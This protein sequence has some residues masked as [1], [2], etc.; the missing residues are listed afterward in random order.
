[1][2]IN[3]NRHDDKHALSPRTLV[4]AMIASW[5]GLQFQWRSQ[6]RSFL[7]KPNVGSIRRYENGR[8]NDPPGFLRFIAETSPDS[9]R[10]EIIIWEASID[11][12]RE[13]SELF[14]EANV[15]NVPAG[16]RPIDR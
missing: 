4:V 9:A 7:T 12:L 15:K 10:D 3:D 11:E 14:P 6:R 8:P 13:A 16:W 1:M 5:I 2:L